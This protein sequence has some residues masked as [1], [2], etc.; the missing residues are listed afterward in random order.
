[1]WKFMWQAILSEERVVLF[2]LLGVNYYVTFKENTLICWLYHQQ[3]GFKIFTDDYWNLGNTYQ[4]V[5]FSFQTVLKK[6][7]FCY[8]SLNI[9]LK[10]MSLLRI[11]EGV[12]TYSTT[13]CLLFDSQEIVLE[14]AITRV[15]L[16][17]WQYLK[18]YYLIELCN[19]TTI[20][21]YGCGF[22]YVKL[23]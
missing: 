10:S 21:F 13:L 3:M 19:S 1:M 16:R 2:C 9:P 22:A 18:R 23:N 14:T 17:Y 8:N 20:C 4:V 11:K 12:R 15:N 6:R 5:F 7:Y